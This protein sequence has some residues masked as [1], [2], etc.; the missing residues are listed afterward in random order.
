MTA[1]ESKPLSVA[2]TAICLVLALSPAI[3]LAAAWGMLPDVVPAHWGAEG[4]DRWGS[5]MEMAVVPAVSFVLGGALLFGARRAHAD[6]EVDFLNWTLSER[7][8]MVVSSI[9]TSL[10]GLGSMAGWIMGTLDTGSA[11]GEAAAAYGI[12]IAI[13]P[14]RRPDCNIVNTFAEGVRLAQEA[15]LGNVRVLVDFYH[16]VCEKESP[17]ILRRYGAEYLRHVHFSCPAIPEIDGVRDPARI[18]GLYEGELARRGWWRTYPSSP[19]EWDYG[20]FVQAVKDCGYDGVN[21]LSASGKTAQQSV[22]HLHFHVL[23]RKQG[24]GLNAWPRLG[25]DHHDLQEVAQRLRIAQPENP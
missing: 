7:V 23:P 5:K 10:I 9:A 15:G 21:I 16:M 8:V 18:S 13:E 20:A 14:V 24:D 2:A 19:D 11:A 17:D 22:P 4:I 3:A 25:K 6:D 12:T 1:S